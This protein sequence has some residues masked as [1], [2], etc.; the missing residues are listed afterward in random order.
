MARYPRPLKANLIEPVRLRICAIG[1][2]AVRPFPKNVTRTVTVT[3]R[4]AGRARTVSHSGP[5]AAGGDR[6]PET[7]AQSTRS[8]SHGSHGSHVSSPESLS[9]SASGGPTGRTAA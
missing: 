9:L 7:A 1:A 4:A 6:E 3:D 8:L 2:D 5:E